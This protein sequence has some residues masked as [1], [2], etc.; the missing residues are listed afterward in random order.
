[1]RRRVEVKWSRWQSWG[2]SIK[3]KKPSFPSIPVWGK[4]QASTYT[5][6]DFRSTMKRTL[7]LVSSDSCSAMLWQS[8]TAI[9]DKQAQSEKYCEIRNHCLVTFQMFLKQALPEFLML[10]LFSLESLMTKC[11]IQ[12]VGAVIS[13]RQKRNTVKKKPPVETATSWRKSCLRLKHPVSW[14]LDCPQGFLSISFLQYGPLI[15]SHHMH[16]C[17]IFSFQVV[18]LHEVCGLF[19][20]SFAHTANVILPSIFQAWLGKG[21]DCVGHCSTSCF[22]SRDGKKIQQKSFKSGI[23]ILSSKSKS[24]WPPTSSY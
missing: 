15:I 2:E 11:L 8:S 16:I 18:H 7:L 22:S 21:R 14:D 17:S 3:P 4:A 13:E 9:R 23:Q 10:E 19:F 12:S 1:M 6:S 5:C 20:F 24:S